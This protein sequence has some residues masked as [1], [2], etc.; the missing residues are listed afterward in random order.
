MVPVIAAGPG[1]IGHEKNGQCRAH[2]QKDIPGR[3]LEQALAA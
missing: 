3:S 1:R 2:S